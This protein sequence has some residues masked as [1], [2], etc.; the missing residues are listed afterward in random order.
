MSAGPPRRLDGER[1]W[2]IARYADAAVLLKSDAVAMIEIA[3]R[4]EKLS[5]RMGGDGF[6]NLILLLGSSHPFQ[7]PPAHDATRAVLRETMAEL[8]RRWTAETVAALVRDLLK[9]HSGGEPFDAV[10]GLA[11]PLPSRVVAG[12]LGLEADRV[13]ECGALAREVSAIWHRDVLPLRVLAAMEEQASRIVALLQASGKR[14][15][16][17]ARLAFLTMAGVDTTAGLLGNAIAILAGDPALQ[18]RL[19]DDPARIPGFVNETLRVRPPLR[20][21]VGRRTCAPV[22]LSDCEIPEGALIEIDLDSVHRDPDAYPDPDRFD[23]ARGGPPTLAF[24]F[25][26]HTCVGAPLARLEARILIEQLLTACTVRPAGAAVRGGTADWNEF[27]SL[28]IRLE[29]RV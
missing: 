20:R 8:A 4:L 13:L 17:F 14:R 10:K 5:A 16:E 22:R 15:D 1:G 26:A 21:L 9:P 18:Q 7:N 6:A 12:T 27:H 2:H 23:I 11:Q 19:R 25:G 24:G 29:R 3:R 28:P